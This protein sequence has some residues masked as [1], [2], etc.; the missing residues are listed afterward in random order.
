MLMEC[1]QAPPLE[2]L[3]ESCLGQGPKV[4]YFR[5]KL[6]SRSLMFPLSPCTSYP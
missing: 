5:V 4:F 3:G 1:N 2:T 6:L